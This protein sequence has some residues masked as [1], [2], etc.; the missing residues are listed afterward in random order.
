MIVRSVIEVSEG[1]L[2]GVLVGFLTMSS[3]SSGIG[4]TRCAAGVRSD[5]HTVRDIDPD[6]SVNMSLLL[7]IELTQAA[8]QSFWL[9]DLA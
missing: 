8:P 7:A 9:N 2:S 5:V 3:R 4:Q 1:V 6:E